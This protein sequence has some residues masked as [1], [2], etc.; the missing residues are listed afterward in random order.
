MMSD[1]ARGLFQKAIPMSGTSFI[2]T[3]S[4]AD[5]KELTE[6]LAKGLGWDG[7]GGERKILE[8][9]ENA[10]AKRIV[11]VE[12]SLLTKEEVFQEHILFPFTPVIEPYVSDNTFLAVDPVLAGR[13]AWSNDID[14][15]IG[16]ASLEGSLFAMYPGFSNFYDFIQ[17]SDAL[18]TR[19]LKPNSPHTITKYGEKLRKLYFGDESPSVDTRLQYLWVIC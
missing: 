15:M 19:E 2:K 17:N 7:N 1:L 14:C 8:V 4:Y 3:W 5:K 11:E 9:L 18:V 13:K 6:R 16:A 10:D 12:M